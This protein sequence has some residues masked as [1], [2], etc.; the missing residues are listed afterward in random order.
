MTTTGGAR[1]DDSM[2]WLRNN[3]RHEKKGNKQ[4]RNKE[5]GQRKRA[6][7]KRAEKRREEKSEPNGENREN[8]GRS[9]PPRVFS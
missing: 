6:E 4:T 1:A 3:R 2:K 8:R 9:G 5:K 7:K